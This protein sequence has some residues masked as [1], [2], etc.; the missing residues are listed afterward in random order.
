MEQATR[1]ELIGG[2]VLLDLV[3]TVAWRLDEVMA[4]DRLSSAADLVQWAMHAGLLD[5]ETGRRLHAEAEADDREA[6]RCLG[7]VRSFRELTYQL[8]RPLAFGEQSE[9]SDLERLHADLLNATAHAKITSIAPLHLSLRPEHLADLPDTLT[10]T[11]WQLL[12]HEDLHSLR[13]CADTAC[14]WLF[15]D[16]S[17]NRSRRWCSSAD[18]GNRA[19]ARRHYN[20]RRTG[21]G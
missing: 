4:T 16:R 12:L 10:L 1:P 7:R 19:R 20:R 21:L 5:P 14:G 18:C 15:L 3:N 11:A 2:H 17:K 13:E 6:D 9:P 8:L